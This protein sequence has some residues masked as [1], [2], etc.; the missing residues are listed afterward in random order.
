M[1]NSAEHLKG[2]TNFLGATIKNDM[3]EKRIPFHVMD[4]DNDDYDDDNDE[5]VDCMTTPL[6]I[7]MES[8]PIAW[9]D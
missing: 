8:Y 3:T 1:M 9:L 5:I 4:R 2:L 6:K 7:V